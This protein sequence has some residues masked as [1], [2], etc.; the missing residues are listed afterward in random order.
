MAQVHLDE[1]RRKEKLKEKATEI[2]AA[3]HRGQ[4]VR[5]GLRKLLDAARQNIKEGEDAERE[6]RKKVAEWRANMADP[7][8]EH[9]FALPDDEKTKAE[10]GAT[11]A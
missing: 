1:K 8:A 9:N 10:T 11:G 4:E 5:N 3:M 2:I 6:R 7:F